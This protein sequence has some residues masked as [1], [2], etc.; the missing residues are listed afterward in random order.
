MG[1]VGG[2]LAFN[3]VCTAVGYCVLALALRGLPARTIA[4][5]CGVALLAGT[6]I[7]G[8]ALCFVAPFGARI[9]LLAAA[10][11]AVARFLPPLVRARPL[12][13]LTPPSRFADAAATAAAAG[14]AVVL[15]L[16][17]VGGF[18][19]SPWLDDTWY[20]WLPKG[21]ALDT[22]GL[23]PRLW[24]PDPSLHM[25]FGHDYESLY[26]IRPDNPLWWSVVLNLVMRFVGTMDMRAVNGELAFLLVAF[27]GATA[28]L[29][30]GRIRPWLLLPGLLLLLSAPELLR[31]TQ[32]GDADVPLAIYLA[33]TVLAAVG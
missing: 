11:L 15:V 3:L 31:Q 20:F 2:V 13:S 28:R 33:L 17:L 27:V 22:V 7:V 19:S 10:G 29:L 32:G 16:V 4:T 9:G 24:R 21:R 18:R 23:D 6:G 14:I 8:V 1:Y 12:P 25:I 26:F 5:Y 30:W